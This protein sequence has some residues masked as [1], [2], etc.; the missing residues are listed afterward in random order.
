MNITISGAGYVGISNALLLA[1]KNNVIAYDISSEKID[2]L[3]SSKSPI[4]DNEIESFL[5]NKSLI[6]LPG[7]NG[8]FIISSANIHP[9]LHISIF[10]LNCRFKRTSG[11]L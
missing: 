7:N 10:S 1:Q 9:I 2:L 3:N 11:D 4:V 8:L 5:K 6:F